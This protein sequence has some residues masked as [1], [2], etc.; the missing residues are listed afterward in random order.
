MSLNNGLVCVLVHEVRHSTGLRGQSHI[1]IMISNA[2]FRSLIHLL[3]KQCENSAGNT[4]VGCI[5]P[6]VHAV[7]PDRW[8]GEVSSPYLASTSLNTHNVA[9]ADMVFP[10]YSVPSPSAT[11]LMH[12]CY[13]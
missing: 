8:D 3:W 1:F 11:N 2:N 12:N 13:V 7:S 9:G 10:L 5:Q 6:S 4:G